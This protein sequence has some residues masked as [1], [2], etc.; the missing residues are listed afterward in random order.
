MQDPDIPPQAEEDTNG[1]VE[2]VHRSAAQVARWAANVRSSKAS[3]PLPWIIATA[4]IW[5]TT[6]TEVEGRDALVFPP[7]TRWSIPSRCPLHEK[8]RLRACS[9]LSKTCSS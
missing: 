5:A 1:A 9:P 3:S 4:P 7:P 6:A 8:T 2:G